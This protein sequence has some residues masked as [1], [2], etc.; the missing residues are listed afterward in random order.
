MLYFFKRRFATVRACLITSLYLLTM[1]FLVTLGFWQL[2][3]AAEK[4]KIQKTEASFAKR[5]AIPWS[6]AMTYPKAYQ[7]VIIT[8]TLLPYTLFLDNQH[9]QHQFGYH[10]LSPLQIKDGKVLLVDRGWIRGD[11]SR[12]QYPNPAVGSRPNLRTDVGWVLTQQQEW[13]GQVYFPSKNNW[14]LGQ[15]IE[16][17]GKDFAVIEKIDPQLIAHLLQKSVYPFIIRLGE[18]EA[19]G[20]ER[21]WHTELVSMS[22]ARHKAYALQWFVMAFVVLVIFIGLSFREKHE[23]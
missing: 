13:L 16:K 18:G 21:A 19:N 8:G 14:D 6:P 7:S 10:V 20:F 22:P 11:P 9:Y 5:A 17:E 15:W 2:Q 4:S 12:R 3:R 1:V 23:V